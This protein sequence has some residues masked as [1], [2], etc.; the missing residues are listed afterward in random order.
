MILCKHTSEGMN[1]RYFFK[2]N[3]VAFEIIL[4]L[5]KAHFALKRE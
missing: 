5:A 2:F 3:V 1:I 4:N